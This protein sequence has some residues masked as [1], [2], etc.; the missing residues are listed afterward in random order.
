MGIDV[1]PA[2]RA[3]AAALAGLALLAT[4]AGCDGMANTRL[5]FSNTERVALTGIR[6]AGGSGDVMIRGD[7]PAGE[8]RIDRVVRY[9]G[10]DP[11]MTYRVSGTDL[12]VDTE[13]GRWCSVSYVI[14]APAG[15]AV[16]GN[17]GSGDVRM[18]DVAAV[19][20]HVGSG[21]IAVTDSTADVT[22][23]TGSGNV[24]VSAVAGALTASAGS[25]TIDAR[26]VMGGPTTVRTGSGDVTLALGRPAAVRGEVGSGDL[27]VIVPTGS[28]RVDVSTGSGD[29]HIGVP[30]SPSG[31][32]LLDLESGSGDIAV[33]SG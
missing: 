18:S 4:L 27:T 1:H 8:V 9:R 5:E 13:C 20:V 7:G 28:Y 30:D 10:D 23:E 25:G 33:N 17:N 26:G 11:G 19:D 14:Q 22:V 16:R 29:A 12:R 31:Q 6:I 2:G 3:G 15:V 24:A 32:H 21:S